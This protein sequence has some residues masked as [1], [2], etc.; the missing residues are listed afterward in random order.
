MVTPPVCLTNRPPPVEANRPHVL[1]F[2][3]HY[4]VYQISKNI[5]TNDC[6]NITVIDLHNDALLAL[7][8]K[9]LL[10]YLKNAKKQGVNE[11]WLSVW[12][13][14][15]KNPFSVIARKRKLLD[16]INGDPQ[17]PIC[18][19]HIEDVWFLTQKNIQRLIYLKPY[20]VSLTWNNPNNLAGGAHSKTGITPLGYKIIK[21]LENAD[22]QI[23]T[24]HLNR[25]SFWQFFKITTRP[26]ICTHTALDA[27]CHHPRNLTNKQIKT[28]IKSGGF[29]GLA[30]VPKFLT[31][32]TTY[33]GIYDVINH[34]AY[35]KRHFNSTKILFGTDFYGTNKLP[36]GISNYQ[37]IKHLLNTQ[38][39]GYSVAKLP[40][41]AYQIG[42]ITAPQR[43][44]ITAS[45]HAREWITS[46][47]LTKWL[48]QTNT[49]PNNY[50]IIAVP[51]C[52][53]DGVK[54]ATTGYES[55][56]KHRQNFLYRI[57]H[58]STNFKLWKANIHAV[59]LNVNFD[60]GWG[61]G[62]SNIFTPAPANYIGPEPH[63]EPE[64]RALL[65]LIKQ[66]KPNQSIALHTKGNLIYYSRIADAQIANKISKITNFP[67]IL[68]INSFGGLTDYLALRYKIPSLTIELGD[69]SLTH[70]ITEEQLP[71]ITSTLTKIIDYFLTGE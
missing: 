13:T 26:I 48:E 35:F 71:Q 44:L 58:K 11:I 8:P 30:L 10:P 40:I 37:D 14:E 27:I 69:D 51:C 24:A 66:T 64:T 29:I 22:I 49:I 53:P 9:K 47:A 3:V 38:I 12:T 46:I 1:D 23:D 52:N 68:S 54:L 7:P 25:R 59:D 56:T 4:L 6:I 39:I 36:Q 55:F 61:H 2:T 15:L 65:R 62:K 5:A 41:I 43:L 21:Q 28:I 17:Y 33:C 20:S 67:A 16:K 57:N 18:R 31:Q 60:I 45:M 42:N 50:C 32:N 63:S 19:L 70:P 34:I